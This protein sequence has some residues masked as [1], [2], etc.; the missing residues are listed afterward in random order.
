MKSDVTGAAGVA[1]TDV[2]GV[3]VSAMTLASTLELFASW[4]DDQR[5][6]YVT[7]TGVH[8]I[9]ECQRDAEL[10]HIHNDADLV[11]SDGMPLVWLH[12]L[13]GK[14]EAERVYGPDLMLEV[15]RVSRERTWRHY[16]YGGAEGVADTLRDALVS[17]FPGLEV[18]GTHCPPFRPLTEEEDDAV[19]RDILESGAHFVWV[20]LSTPKQE[21]FM[22]A[23]RERLPGVVLVG[24]GA[25][26]DFHA[27]LKRQA[28]K[29]MQRSGLEWLFRLGTEPRRLA[30]RYLRNNPEFVWLLLQDKLRQR[31]R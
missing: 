16:F 17:K 5:G 22:A 23:H 26:F 19:C 1:T 10:R 2:L 14:G 18:V 13:D 25:A 6:A 4:I 27:G 7:V 12:W 11:T 3:E 31:R 20:G 30:G 21:R 8:G 28:P 15:C 9:M 29:W 24:V